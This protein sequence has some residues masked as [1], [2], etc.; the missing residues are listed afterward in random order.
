[1]TKKQEGHHL[2]PVVRSVVRP[3]LTPV[4]ESMQIED[5][6]AGFSHH[7]NRYAIGL[8]PQHRQ[9]KAKTNQR[10]EIS[11]RNTHSNTGWQETAQY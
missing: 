10:H 2:I 4:R 5:G 9:Y 8:L 3:I 11:R 7:L 6:D 1:M